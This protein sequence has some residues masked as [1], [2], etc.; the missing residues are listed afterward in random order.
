MR[1]VILGSCLGGVWGSQLGS[2]TVKAELKQLQQSLGRV[3]VRS[4]GQ[5]FLQKKKVFSGSFCGRVW[6]WYQDLGA[7]SEE[8]LRIQE[9]PGW[10]LGWILQERDSYK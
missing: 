2:Q 8:L 6:G 4:R 5:S 9:M 3:S 7:L 1:K 10:R